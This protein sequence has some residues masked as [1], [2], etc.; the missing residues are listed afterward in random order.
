MNSRL[1]RG[2]LS[3][4]QLVDGG[5]A[6]ALACQQALDR[7]ANGFRR[8]GQSLA[9]VPEGALRQSLRAVRPGS[10]VGWGDRLRRKVR[11]VR[12]A[13]ECAMELGGPA[14]RSEERRVG[15]GG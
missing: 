9:E 8:S 1:L 10:D 3:L 4:G 13:G 12:L 11:I 15:K 7:T 14:T 2:D 6:F 5:Q